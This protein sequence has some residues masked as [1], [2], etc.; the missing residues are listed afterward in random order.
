MMP[1]IL[2]LQ[3]KEQHNGETDIESDIEIQ[4]NRKNQ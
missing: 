2:D 4:L 1:T 3:K